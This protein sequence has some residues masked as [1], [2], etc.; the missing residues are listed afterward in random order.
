M[1]DVG[2]RHPVAVHQLAEVL[3]LGQVQR[4]AVAVV[5]VAG[6][7]LV[8]PRQ[9]GRFVWRADVFHVPVGDH[10]RAVRD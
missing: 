5:V 3:R 7:L 1:I 9:P 4:E 6:V 2:L 8:E 10:L